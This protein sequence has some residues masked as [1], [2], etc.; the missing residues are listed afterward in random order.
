MGSPDPNG[1]QLNGMGAGVSSLSKVCIVAKS[2]REGVDVDYTFVGIGIEGTETDVAGN[3]GNM[4]AAVGP[5]AFDHR[6][7]G[8]EEN[9]YL[10]R[11][12]EVVVRIYNTN[13]GVVIRSTFEVEGGE[14]KAVGDF[15][16][17]GVGGSGSKINLEFL[18]PGGSKTGKLLPTGKATDTIEGVR[19]SCV[20]AANPGIF[21]KAEDVGIDPTILP[22]EFNQLTEKRALL[23][24]IRGKGAE[25]MGLCKPG[26]EP[27]RVIPKIA[28]VSPPVTQTT[29]SGE[30]VDGA[31]LDLVV[32]FISD[33]QPH[34]AIPLTGALCT[35]AAAKI[36]GTIVNEVL[37][38]EQLST[39][40]ITMGHPSGRIQVSASRGTNGDI[41][42]ASVFRTARRVMEGTV[43]W[44]E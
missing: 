36:P 29:L 4:S 26:E 38:R 32:R 12:G 35:A 25:M 11:K 40:M 21:V 43:F 41:E 3:C 22:H 13:T 18:R 33:S 6:L 10:E 7:L 44:N 37:R 34:R 28:I 23:E 24:R 1:R 16:I 19:T 9:V 30:T 15:M 31:S 2:A 42:S 20:D 8:L 39:G 17:D 5:Y 14:A 27:P